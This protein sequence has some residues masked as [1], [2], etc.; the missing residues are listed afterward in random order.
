MMVCFGRS[1]TIQLLGRPKLRGS[2]G[3]F[4]KE[5][6]TEHENEVVHSCEADESVSTWTRCVQ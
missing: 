1:D 5:F 2:S 3:Q 4:H 6:N